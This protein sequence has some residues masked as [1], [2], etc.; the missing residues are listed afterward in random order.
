MRQARESADVYANLQDNQVLFTNLPVDLAKDAEIMSTRDKLR[1][2]LI[3]KVHKDL[4]VKKISHID[5]I[6]APDAT[7]RTAF[8]KVTLGSKRQAFMV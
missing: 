7:P 1:Q 2:F 5:A 3:E 4:Q 8:I 6:T